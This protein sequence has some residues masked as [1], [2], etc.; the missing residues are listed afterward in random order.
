MV[1]TGASSVALSYEDARKGGIRAADLAFEAP[2]STANGVVNASK[3]II[4]R[5]EVGGYH[6]G[7]CG[8]P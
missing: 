2:V 6:R 5:I 8:R 3:V 1:D 4:R 7:G